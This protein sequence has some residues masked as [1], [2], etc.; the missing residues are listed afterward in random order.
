MQERPSQRLRS[1]ILEQVNRSSRPIRLPS[2][3][4]LA[5]AWG[6]S[7]TTVRAVVHELAREVPVTAVPGRGTLV[8][9]VGAAVAVPEPSS[10]SHESVGEAIL[11]DI[12]SGELKTGDALPQLKHVCMRFRIHPSTASRAYARLEQLGVVTR[13]GKRYW[14]GGFSALTMHHAGQC[15]VLFA[16]SYGWLEKKG[17]PQHYRLPLQELEQELTRHG[18]AMRLRRFD[19]MPALRRGWTRSGRYPLGL[20]FLYRDQ[21]DYRRLYTAARGIR[22]RSAIQRPAFVWIGG[23]VRSRD[24]LGDIYCHGTVSTGIARRLAAF[25]AEHC[26]QSVTVL[27]R[28][29]HVAFHRLRDLLRLIPE[30]YRRGAGYRVRFAVVA[31]KGELDGHDDVVEWL[32][33]RCDRQYL[34]GVIGKYG[35]LELHD[36][37]SLFE[38]YVTT[39]EAFERAAK[40]GLWICPAAPDARAAQAWLERR[41]V[42]CPERVSLVCLEDLRET[43]LAGISCIVPDWRTIGYLLA[44]RLI[45]D[46]PVDHS[47]RGYV[48]TPAR[49]VHRATTRG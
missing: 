47:H 9:E 26:L 4:D 10:F 49:V 17:Q 2:Q 3:A 39:E 34:H 6:V 37:H 24:R 19:E 29:R 16:E 22:A 33:S 21:A 23:H 20:V 41:R 30:I 31:D 48:R 5:T 46:I 44:H 36:L 42:A 43:M 7:E 13:V 45:G 25:A 27:L 8:G 38:H 28:L 11:A 32:L 14:V 18:I 40:E 12:R 1:W 15:V 35:E